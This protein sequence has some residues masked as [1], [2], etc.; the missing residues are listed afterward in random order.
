M[1]VR[2]FHRVVTNE[3]EVDVRRHVNRVFLDPVRAVIHDIEVTRETVTLRVN[4][5]K[6]QV[7]TR[8]SVHHN[9]VHDV[10][11]VEGHGERGTQG[12]HKTVKE[13]SHT[14]LVQIHVLEDRIHV[15]VERLRID[16]ILHTEDTFFLQHFLLAVRLTLVVLL[17][18]MFTDR[19][20]HTWINTRRV[21]IFLYKLEVLPEALLEIHL[22]VVQRKRHT[23]V[24]LRRVL[25]AAGHV[26]R[27]LMCDYVLDQLHRRVTL[28][29][30]LAFAVLGRHHDI[31]QTVHVRRQLHLH[32]FPA[33]T[34]AER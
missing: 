31:L 32:V 20:C 23:A 3:I 4:R 15:L 12:R 9:R 30:V 13:Q 21:D 24:G 6:S 34:L 14:V 26:E 28:A 18:D 8:I 22:Q 25:V 17:T 7:N 16:D 10:V 19:N 1:F 11:L 33:L 5:H 29:F 2:G 27:V